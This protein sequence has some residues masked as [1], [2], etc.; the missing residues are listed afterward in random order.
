VSVLF[1]VAAV[2]FFRLTKEK[3]EVAGVIPAEQ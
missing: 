1:V 3:R 2:L